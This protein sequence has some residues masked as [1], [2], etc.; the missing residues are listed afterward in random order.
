M[1]DATAF[2]VKVRG[3]TA[4]VRKLSGLDSNK[5]FR[6]SIKNTEDIFCR[7]ENIGMMNCPNT[8][9]SVIG[10]MIDNADM[11]LWQK[12]WEIFYDTYIITI[13]QMAVNSFKAIGWNNVDEAALG[14]IISET[15][16][17]L[18]KAFENKT[19]TPDKYRFRGF[20]KRIVYRRTLDYIRA[21][22]SARTVSKDVIEIVEK[23]V[24]DSDD[25]SYFEKLEENEAN[26][27]RMSVI[28]DIWESIRHSF[29]PKTCLCFELRMLEEMP[30][31]D[32]CA[33]LNVPRTKVDKSVHRII[34]RL[35][36]ETQKEYYK[37][38]IQL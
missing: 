8:P 24:C 10:K 27:Y 34:K 21:Q 3:N 30:V 16:L 14:A 37:K 2:N 31:E 7:N 4:C 32:I 28:M 1:R 23:T 33:K 26:A 5:F 38:E 20:L 13:R 11:K 22:N 25:T 9:N 6:F 17:S 15:F 12:S 18:Q 36:E 19:Y 29:D 35:R